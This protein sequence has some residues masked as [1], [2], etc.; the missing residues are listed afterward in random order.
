MAAK[1]V[2]KKSGLHGRGLFAACDLEAGVKLIEY[3][4]VRYG[5]GEM[6]DLVDEGHTRFL[7]LS[8]GTGIDGTGWAALANHACE[9]NCELAEEGGSRPLRAWLYTLRPVRKGEELVWDYRLQVPCRSEAYAAWACACGRD[10]CRGTM[11]DPDLFE[12]VAAAPSR[13]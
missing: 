9:A 6:P 11:A 7:R 3:K 10:A 5:E 12:E 1:V 2:V 13:E 4:G 8:D